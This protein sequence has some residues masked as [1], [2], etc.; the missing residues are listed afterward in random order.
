[1]QNLLESVGVVISKVINGMK[2][3]S[4]KAVYAK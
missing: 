1:M 3:D 2:K 4:N